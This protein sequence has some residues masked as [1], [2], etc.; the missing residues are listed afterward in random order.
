LSSDVTQLTDLVPGAPRRPRTPQ[1]RKPQRTLA[2]APGITASPDITSETATATVMLDPVPPSSDVPAADEE[3]VS[4]TV[5]L[6]PVEVRA[7]GQRIREPFYDQLT[8]V[9]H[10]LGR[11]RLRTTKTEMLEFLLS[12]LPAGQRDLDALAHEVAEFRSK[13][14]RG[15]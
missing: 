6:Q 8:E 13:H 2:T 3:T 15:L 11:R 12:R 9:V 10:E 14:R 1:P 5:M 7:L 4:R